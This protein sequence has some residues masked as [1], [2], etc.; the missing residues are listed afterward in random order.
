MKSLGKGIHLCEQSSA[1]PQSFYFE[2]LDNFKALLS[3]H[4]M[5]MET[6]FVEYFDFQ[7]IQIPKEFLEFESLMRD[8]YQLNQ[9]G[10][11]R[12]SLERLTLRDHMTK[13]SYYEELPRD[14][15]S[16]LFCVF[17]GLS[18]AYV[19]GQTQRLR[20]TL[21]RQIAVP[22]FYICQVMGMPM[23]NGPYP[24]ARSLTAMNR[25]SLLELI[26]G[27]NHEL[28]FKDVRTFLNFTDTITE[29]YFIEIVPMVEI[30][31][32]RLFPI[33]F[34]LNQIAYFETEWLLSRT[35]VLGDDSLRV[36]AENRGEILSEILSLLEDLKRIVWYINKLSK[37]MIK[38]INPVEFYSELR[39]F[40][41]GYGSFREGVRFEG[42]DQTLFGD[43]SFAGQTGAW[44]FLKSILNFEY[45]D[46]YSSYSEKLKKGLCQ[47]ELKFLNLANSITLIKPLIA[48]NPEIHSKYSECQDALRE[49]YSW[50]NMMVK[51]FIVKPA[52]ALDSKE[53][54]ELEGVGATPLTD[55]LELK[56]CIAPLIKHN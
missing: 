27:N 15:I 56:H 24:M 25:K 52:K 21:P 31:M 53:I 44:S 12:Q 22:F 43:G 50:H 4:H 54:A 13:G 47:N 28:E 48:A 45:S 16:K 6:G 3:D 18:T 20:A 10:L 17:S 39:L 37:E 34:R 1:K 5:S 33:Y 49:F 41:Q 40:L 42:I 14:Q 2:S 51:S 7:E 38:N 32:A 36:K 9:K 8:F 23:R 55:V 19:F 30:K 26:S 35:S 29:K 46:K 11:F